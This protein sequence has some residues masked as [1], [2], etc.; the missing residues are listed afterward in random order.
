LARRAYASTLDISFDVRGGLLMRQI[1]HWAALLFV[2]AIA[3]HMMRIFFTG[4]FRKPREA[5]WIIGVAMF[6]LAAAEGFLGYSL[7]DDALSGTGLRIAEGVLLS[8]PVVGTYITF[9][10]FGGPYPGEYIIPRFYI[11]HVL[12]IPG[13]LLALITAHLM[14]I[15]LHGH[16][17]W[18]G[19]KERDDTEVGNPL[20][21]V[22]MVKTCAVLFFTFAALAIAGTFAQ[23]DPV[24]LYGPYSAEHLGIVLQDLV[25]G[26]RF[27]FFVFPAVAFLATRYACLG[28]QR[29]DLR[30]L[31]RGSSR[32]SSSRRRTRLRPGDPCADRGGTGPAGDPPP[33]AATGSRASPP[34]KPGKT[35]RPGN[36]ARPAAKT[37]TSRMVGR[38]P[39]RTSSTRP[40]QHHLN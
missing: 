8:I 12:L 24:W 33:R 32:G 18:S 15:W 36:T 22:F 23:I 11:L 28:L 30:T 21:R 3:V 40:V 38:P 20:Y 5:N 14:I 26:L 1:H 35:A 13:L 39:R 34:A 4:G 10:L 9:F 17:Q 19:K 31:A 6:A 2:A 7:P 29:H 27:G 16:T 37:D 25:W